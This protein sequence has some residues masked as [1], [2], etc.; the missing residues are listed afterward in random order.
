MIDALI[1]GRPHGKPAQRTGPSGKPFVVAKV[2]TPLADGESTFVSV[3]AFD[4]G[5]A[6]PG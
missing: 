3:I 6:R 4:A 2:R 5:T 1:S